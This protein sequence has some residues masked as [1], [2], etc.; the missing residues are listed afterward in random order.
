MIVHIRP[1]YSHQQIK[2]R[3]SAPDDSKLPNRIM[4]ARA[5]V[6]RQ[7]I[8]AAVPPMKV[9]LASLA[10]DRNGNFSFCSPPAEVFA[11]GDV[12]G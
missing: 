5:T 11:L 2:I 9:Y 1:G 12:P 4:A 7:R 8:M 3:P 10:V 6:G